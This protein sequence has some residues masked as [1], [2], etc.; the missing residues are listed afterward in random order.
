M[1]NSPTRRRGRLLRIIALAAGG[2]VVLAVA[3]VAVLVATFDPNSYKPQIVA[4]VR[5][6]TGRELNIGGRIGLSISLQPTLEVSDVSFSNPPGFSRPQMVTLHKLELQ[7]A[8]VPL[9]SKQIQIAR[10]VLDQP[11]ILLETDAKGQSNWQFASAGPAPAAP[12]APSGTAAAAAPP[13]IALSSVRIEGGTIALRNAGQTTTLGLARLAA[14]AA[15]AD[16]PLHLTVD[17]T[18]NATPVGLTA[19][20]GPLSALT[21]GGAA[22]WPVKLAITA[23]GAKFGVDGTVAQPATGRGLALA[24]T[25][26]IPDLAALSPLAGAPLPPLKAIAAQFKLAD[27]DG[28]NTIA[29]SDLKLSLPKLDLAGSASFRRGARPMV[30]ADL[31]GKQID[32]DALKASLS[33]SAPGKPAQPAAPAAR[34]GHVIPDTR[35]PLDALRQTDAD[36]QLAL[37]DLLTGGQDYKAVKLHLVARDGKLTLDPAGVNTPGG[38]VDAKLTMDANPAAPPVTLTLRAPGLALQ[39]LLK[40]LGKPGYASGTLELRADLHGAGDSPHAIAASL[41][42]EIGAAVAKGEMDS[43]VLGGLLSSLLQSTQINQLASKAG[44]SALNCFALRLDASHGAGTLRTLKLD[45]STV[46]LDGTGGMNFGSETLDLHLKPTVGVAGTNVATPVI[47]KGTFAAPSVEPDALGLVTGNVGTAAKLALG[48]STGGLA[49][50]A[51]SAIDK[52][53]SGDP[54]AEPLALARFSA[55]PAAGS[56]PAAAS[57]PQAK[58][59]TGP[60]GTLKGLFQ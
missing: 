40:A 4:A 21:G 56:Q 13:T 28:G 11:D 31:A 46:G 2:L 51:G 10:L 54:C 60:V 53:L 9:L 3:A 19:D 12:A 8:L 44:M 26:D 29:A 34:S 58:P 37:D 15:S 43:Q 6:A 49:L 55:P 59:S 30:T 20:T 39:A 47:V 27:A 1:A 23:A 38:Q 25:A 41:D 17:A 45:S 14:T 42:G 36:V 35:L 57:Q 18:Y 33:A 16:A 22:P 5:S 48:A 32:L 7:L 24:V 52:K 50:I